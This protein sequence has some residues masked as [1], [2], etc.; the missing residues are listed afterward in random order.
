[1]DRVER[2]GARV[3]VVFGGRVPAEPHGPL[4]RAMVQNTPPEYR[5]RR[6]WDEIGAWSSGIADQLGGRDHEAA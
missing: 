1:M 6:D 3:H 4:E 2:L 5:D